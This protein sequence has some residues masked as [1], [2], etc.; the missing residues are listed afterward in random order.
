MRSED[1]NRRNKTPTEILANKTH[2]HW[3]ELL[4][5]KRFKRA[6]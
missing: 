3:L 1:A 2:D 6:A 4:G 5:F